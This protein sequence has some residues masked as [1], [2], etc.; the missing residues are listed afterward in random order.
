MSVTPG[1]DADEVLVP[2]T[3]AIY[4]TTNGTLPTSATESLGE[5][6][7]GHGYAF[8]DD[9]VEVNPRD[10]ATEKEIRA[11]QND[12]LLARIFRG[13]KLTAA[14]TLVQVNAANVGLYFNDTPDAS[15]KVRVRPNLPPDRR[16]WVIDIVA[17]DRVIRHVIPSGEATPSGPQRY[18]NDTQV[19]FPITI[20]GFEDAD[21]VAAAV[22]YSELSEVDE[23]SPSSPSSSG[24]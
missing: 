23:S 16:K 24:A 14:L 9:G 6:W 13:G 2:V 12:A 3:G 22:Y 11:F 20:T 10:G 8:K 5:G 7:V 15:G 19:G 18:L 21:G 4:S 17:G 1:L